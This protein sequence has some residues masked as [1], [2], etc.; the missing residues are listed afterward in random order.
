MFIKRKQDNATASTAK[1]CCKIQAKK[2]FN[3]LT[4]ENTPS[5]NFMIFEVLTAVLMK[6]SVISFCA[7]GHIVKQF[8]NMTLLG[9][10]DHV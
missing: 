8:Y 2:D 7:E 5:T 9:Q 4:N 1:V 3:H 10:S 6:T